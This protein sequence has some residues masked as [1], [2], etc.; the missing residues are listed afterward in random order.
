[1]SIAHISAPTFTSSA[2]VNYLISETHFPPLQNGSE[3]VPNVKQCLIYRVVVEIKSIHVK[4][5]AQYLALI[6]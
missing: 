5:S 1:M 3:A 4:F 6:Q 2:G